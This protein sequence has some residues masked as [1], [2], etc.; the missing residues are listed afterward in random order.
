MPCCWLLV[1]VPLLGTGGF[2]Q[3]VWASLGQQEFLCPLGGQLFSQWEA[4]FVLWGSPRPVEVPLEMH[5][6]LN[7][8][9]FPGSQESAG[10]LSLQLFVILT[11]HN[12]HDLVVNL[13]TN[14]LL[15]Q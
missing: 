12:H 11:P 9:G 15:F 10:R 14:M 7:L 5:C 6:C 8:F 13:L 3:P 1:N 4:P 2:F